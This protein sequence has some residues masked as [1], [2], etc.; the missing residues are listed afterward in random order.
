MR[1]DFLSGPVKTQTRQSQ[2]LDKRNIC[3]Q[4]NAE[5]FARVRTYSRD[6]EKYTGQNLEP[7]IEKVASKIYFGS[8]F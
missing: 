4:I 6:K 1:P 5:N 8:K 2:V 3:M 7:K